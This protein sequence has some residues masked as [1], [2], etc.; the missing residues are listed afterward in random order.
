MPEYTIFLNNKEEAKVS[1]N[2]A[3]RFKGPKNVELEEKNKFGKDFREVIKEI[4]ASEN[5]FG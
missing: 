5:K 2:P 4:Q 3:E 1:V